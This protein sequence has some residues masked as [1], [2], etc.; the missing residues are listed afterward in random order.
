MEDV[1]SPGAP[2]F[3]IL[4]FTSSSMALTSSAA[5][6][7]SELE[8]RTDRREDVWVETERRG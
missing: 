6:G 2:L 4:L 3:T 1:A 7:V 8:G 5:L